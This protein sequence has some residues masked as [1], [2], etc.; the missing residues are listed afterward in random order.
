[1]VAPKSEG[2][3][4]MLLPNDSPSCGQTYPARGEFIVSVPIKLVALNG[5]AFVGMSIL[6]FLARIPD[7]GKSSAPFFP[8][9]VSD[10]NNSIDLNVPFFVS[11]KKCGN[12][13]FPNPRVHDHV[14]M[15]I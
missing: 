6:I 8:A 4:S 2:L 7:S 9:Q 10:G 11:L 12:A 3:K 1:M 5:P 15:I 14:P 13:I